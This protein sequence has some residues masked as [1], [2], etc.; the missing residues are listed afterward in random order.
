MSRRDELSTIV[1]ENKV[2]AP[3]V[4]EIIFLEEKLAEYR[5][6]PFIR[7]NPNNPA[8]HKMTPAHKAYK[9]LLQQYTNCVKVLDRAVN[10]SDQSDEDSPLRQF[11]QDILSGSGGFDEFKR[12]RGG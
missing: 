8:Q 11:A 3:L 9:E 6:L 5:A 10:G 4:D 12:S 1:G 2:L 7:V